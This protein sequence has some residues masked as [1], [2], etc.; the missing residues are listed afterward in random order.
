MKKVRR[1]RERGGGGGGRERARVRTRKRERESERVKEKG[2]CA[3]RGYIPQG[4]DSRTMYGYWAAGGIDSH[5]EGATDHP[6]TET[7]AVPALL[8]LFHVLHPLPPLPSLGSYVQPSSRC[9]SMQWL[10]T[11]LG[12]YTISARRASTVI[13]KTPIAP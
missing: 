10:N 4:C 12:S 6:E 3:V 5:D 13:S 11:L 1:K 9:A 8:H 7:P 2:G